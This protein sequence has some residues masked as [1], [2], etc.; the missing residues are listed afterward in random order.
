MTKNILFLTIDGLRSDKFFGDTKTSHTP[1]MDSLRKQGTYFEQAVSCADG[2]T[3]SLNAI[4]SGYFP[5]R[6]GTRAGEVQMNKSNFLYVLKNS[7]YHI[8]GITHDLSS[9]ARLR[10]N[11][12]NRIK[13]FYCA[14]PKIQ[15]LDE[16]TGKLIVDLLT[17]EKMKEP[18][19]CYL[20]PMDLH[21]PLI[22][23]ENFT[24]N[25]FGN[26]KYEKVLS[27]IDVWIKRIFEEIDLDNTLVV[28]TADHGSII[29]EGDVGFSD[30]EPSFDKGLKIGKKVMPSSTHKYGAKMITG[31]KNKIREKRLKKAN[32]GL[33]SYQ[34][35]SR[36]PYFRL[37]LFDEAIRI[38]LL[39][40][41]K[42]IPKNKIVSSQVCNLDIFPTLLDL[43]NIHDNVRR[44]GRNLADV[45]SGKKIQ[46]NNIF[47]HTI[48]Y[49]E[50][51]VHD[52]IGIRTSHYKYF[53][54]ARSKS[55]KI[56]LYDL[57]QDPS[58]N[59]NIAN[60][61][62]EI[63]LEMEEVLRE[64][65]QDSI[66]EN[67]DSMNDEQ[68]KKIQDELRLLGYKKSKLSHDGSCFILS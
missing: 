37:T 28:I 66:I 2:T 47:L 52:K 62:P 48:L 57:H 46:E 40:I 19:F 14:P 51:S 32:E 16:G 30:F 17:K 20:H 13:S 65:T 25:K 60:E 21:D 55:E 56:N 68:L 9:L 26:N 58:E 50:K 11:I 35:R 33:T 23:P 64:M 24:A 12:E 38:P 43:V 42:N 63:I 22:V 45:F 5:F 53:R 27:S 34:K 15:R 10:F 54:Q 31:I 4:F 61:N 18:W 3:L 44:D 41:G 59:N 29:P 8:Y 36:L 6:T 7:G 49:D 1:F 39:F 67:M